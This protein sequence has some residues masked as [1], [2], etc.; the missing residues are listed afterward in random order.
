MDDR[1]GEMPKIHA[2]VTVTFTIA[3]A[4]SFFPSSPSTSTPFFMSRLDTNLFK[5]RSAAAIVL[6]NFFMDDMS[7]V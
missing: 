2:M 4:L 7:Y 1:K 6:Y 3:A 5:Q